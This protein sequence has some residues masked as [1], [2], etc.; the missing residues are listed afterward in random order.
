ML[1]GCLA[2][3]GRLLI[4]FLPLLD[5]VFGFIVSSCFGSQ[6]FFFMKLCLVFLM[7]LCAGMCPFEPVICFGFSKLNLPGKKKKKFA[8]VAFALPFD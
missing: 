1:I 2:W 5:L 7:Y 4:D 6:L 8:Q 3:N